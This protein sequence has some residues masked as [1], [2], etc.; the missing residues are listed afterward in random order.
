MARLQVIPWLGCKS[1]LK[2]IPAHLDRDYLYI[3]PQGEF[4]HWHA[5]LFV[6]KNTA[7]IPCTLSYDK[8]V[9]SKK[10]EKGATPGSEEICGARH[11]S[12]PA[13][14]DGG[15]PGEYMP[16]S[17]SPLAGT[18]FRGRMTQDRIYAK[19]AYQGDK[20]VKAKLQEKQ[21]C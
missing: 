8:L 7:G 2:G 16:L 6:G 4:V 12:S 3:I 19:S 17:L 9:P 10:P 14:L 5:S 18:L 1:I 21:T 11:W 20:F 13:S 15:S